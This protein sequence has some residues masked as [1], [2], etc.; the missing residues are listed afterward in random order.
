MELRGRRIRAG[1]TDGLLD[2]LVLCG[3][4][5]G[6]RELELVEF[7]VPIPADFRYDDTTGPLMA[8]QHAFHI[9][10]GTPDGGILRSGPIGGSLAGRG[11][12]LRTTAAQRRQETRPEPVD[13]RPEGRQAGADDPRIAF[14]G[15]PH[16]GTR[17]VI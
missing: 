2:Q 1:L 16:G 12:A 10:T 14:D 5:V 9:V 3:S 8:L 17:I 11:V 6:V 7:N 15:G 4:V 13:Q